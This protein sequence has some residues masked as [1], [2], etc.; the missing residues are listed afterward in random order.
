MGGQMRALLILTY[1]D[2]S[3][4][5]FEG[6]KEFITQHWEQARGFAETYSIFVAYQGSWVCMRRNNPWV[7]GEPSP[8]ELLDFG[9]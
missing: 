9:S 2:G 8:L 1:I 7:D 6:P 5:V 4:N 3:Q